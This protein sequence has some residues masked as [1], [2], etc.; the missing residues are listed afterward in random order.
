VI[1]VSR[2]GDFGCTVG[3]KAFPNDWL[4]RELKERT[5]HT[6]KLE[7]TPRLSEALNRL[8]IKVTEEERQEESLSIE[9]LKTTPW[10]TVRLDNS[11]EL[12]FQE[13]LRKA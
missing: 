8:K 1:I 9:G 10:Q 3:S 12:L 2:D 11:V 5:K 7:L 4:F 13:Y 6:R